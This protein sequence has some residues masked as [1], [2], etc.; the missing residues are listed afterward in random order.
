MFAKQD[1]KASDI[2]KMGL[3]LLATG[4]LLIQEIK[5]ENTLPAS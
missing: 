4:V 3:L 1:M 5:C 2:W